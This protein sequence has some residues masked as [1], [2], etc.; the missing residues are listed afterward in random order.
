MENAHWHSSFNPQQFLSRVDLD[1]LIEHNEAH[2]ENKVDL[3]NSPCILCNGRTTPGL[4]LNDKSYLCKNCFKSTSAISYPEKYEKLWREYL[5]AVEARRLALLEF[6]NKYEYRKSGN[7]VS[8]FA[9]LSLLLLFVSIGFIVLTIILFFVSSRIDKSE[10][11]KY[12]LWKKQLQEWGSSYP[13][14]T[15]PVLRHFHDPFAELTARDY[16]ILKIFNNWPGYPPF[17]GYLRD[18][19]LDRDQNRC[20]V[21]GCPSRLSLHVH[22]KMPVSKGGEHVPANLVSLCDFHH[23]LEPDEGHERLWGNVKTRYFTLVREHMRH[24]RNSF[25]LHDV[26]SHLRRLELISLSELQTLHNIY[27]YS[28]PSCRS[29]GLKFTLF[30]DKNQIRIICKECGT[31]WDGPQQLTEE[32]GPK[33]AEALV[34]TKNLGVWK[35]RWDMLENRKDSAFKSFVLSPERVKTKTIKTR[36]VS[37]TSAERPVC[38]KC[39]SPM[40]LIKPRSGQKWKAFWGCSKYRITGCHGSIDL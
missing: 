9:W 19:V 28:C 14:P 21:T 26:T 3:L 7:S 29:L 4:I 23:A 22:H 36:K 15:K 6:K 13:D 39:G 20:Q 1:K 34:A 2:N 33:L 5:K 17:W 25:G 11:E 40:R 16:S 32:V 24:N 12:L 18:V 27:G 10:N 31:G 35:P 30:S 37:S 38:P 8:G